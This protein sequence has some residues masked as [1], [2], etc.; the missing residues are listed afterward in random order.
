M[1]GEL[2]KV[3]LSMTMAGWPLQRQTP[4]SLGIW[5]NCQFFVNQDIEECD[6]WVVYDDM[7]R[8]EQTQCCPKNTLLIMGEPP[9]V[10][11]YPPQYL[12][13]FA[14][15]L[16]VQPHIK[17]QDIIRTHLGLP[18]LIG[19]CYIKESNSWK[20]ETNR[21]YDELKSTAEPEKNKLISVIC[22][23][24]NFTLGHT[25]R[26][27]FVRRLQRHFGS[28]LDVFGRGVNDFQDKWEAIAPYK[29]HIAIENGSLRNYWT[30]KLTDALLGWS[31]PFYYGCPNIGDYFSRDAFSLLNLD[32]FDGS[33][34][35]IEAA[36]RQD[37][38]QSSTDAR[39]QARELIL[40]EYNLFSLLAN[41]ISSRW[42]PCLKV[43]MRLK[44][45]AQILGAPGERARRLIHKIATRLSRGSAL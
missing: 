39:R 26:L 28:D 12:A 24:K 21:N 23:D 33:V 36:I 44:T 18:W 7:L 30:E 11:S 2:I 41:V 40:D 13:Q 20:S 14:T 1:T 4:G 43:D 38:Y 37:A 10:K 32:D 42:T 45:E 35:Q 31:Y 16:T 6:Y 8:P 9:S 5:K 15:I 17:H 25:Q 34:R 27:D 22:S 29:Y 19:G 3:K